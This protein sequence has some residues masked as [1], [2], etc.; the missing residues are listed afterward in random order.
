[1]GALGLGGI[2]AVTIDGYGTLVDLDDPVGR[3]S[4]ALGKDAAAA[5]EVE[6]AY[7]RAHSLEGRDEASLAELRL[8]CTRVF[9]QA[10]DDTRDP[11]TFVD[12]FQ[13]ALRFELIPGV[14]E[15]LHSLRAHGLALAVVSNWDFGLHVHLRRIGIAHLFD[16][17][18]TSAEARVAKPDARIFLEALSRLRVAPERALHVGDHAESDEQGARV[19][20]M[21]FAFA[22]LADAFA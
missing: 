22:P 13:D 4:E 16:A 3:L 11:A 18:V 19:A 12:A 2:D 20:G 6:G 5:W 10:A 9:L 1:V 15:S 14:V 17:V 21:Q 7:Y 8:R